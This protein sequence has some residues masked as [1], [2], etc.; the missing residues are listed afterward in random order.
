MSLTVGIL[1]ALL[2]RATHGVGQRVEVDLF[3]SA[4]AMQCQEISALLNLDEDW[5]RSEAGIGGAWLNA[6]FGLYRAADGWFALSMADL[7]EVG[8]I[9][10]APDLADLDPWSDRDAVKRRID[11]LVAGGTVESTVGRLLAAGLWA[12]PVRTTSEAVHELRETGSPLIRDV[13]RADGTRISLVGS[14]ITLSGTPWTLRSG[15]PEPGEHTREVLEQFLGAEAADRL[16][17]ASR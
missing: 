16:T 17:A 1:A 2:A 15:P 4:I 12:A 7:A 5:A 14:P 6:P 11:A 9:L 3:S 8:A 13:T 10:D